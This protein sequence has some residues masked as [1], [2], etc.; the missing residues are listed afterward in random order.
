METDPRLLAPHLERSTMVFS[1]GR[2]NEPRLLI[3]CA[4][5][6]DEWTSEPQLHPEITLSTR[7]ES[8]STKVERDSKKLFRSL[9][10]GGGA[11][12]KQ[13]EMGTTITS[14]SILRA[15]EGVMSILF[16]NDVGKSKASR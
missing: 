9:L 7:T 2:I 11:A 16:P 13:N 14:D 8:G 6:L 1:S 12:M 5:T 3:S 15:A 10:K 4:L